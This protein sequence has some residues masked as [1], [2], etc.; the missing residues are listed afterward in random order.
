MEDLAQ[1]LADTCEY[2]HAMMD[3][4]T[5]GPVGQNLYASSDV[6]LTASQ[7]LQ[8]AIALWDGERDNYVYDDNCDSTAVC[9]TCSGVCG[10][11]TQV[12]RLTN[13]LKLYYLS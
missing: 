6:G 11:H 9:G 3:H 5:L 13:T 4:S 2:V 7:H 10:H 8:A 12:S 1:S